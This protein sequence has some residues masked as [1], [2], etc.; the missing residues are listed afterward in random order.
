MFKPKQLIS[1]FS[2]ILLTTSTA[3]AAFTDL[4]IGQF[5]YHASKSLESQTTQNLDQKSTDL[6]NRIEALKYILKILNSQN[7]SPKLTERPRASIQQPIS[8][9]ELTPPAN[10]TNE[11]ILTEA[12]KL[13]IINDTT[14]QN[15][16]PTDPITRA[17]ALKMT[18]SLAKVNL[19]ST[20][21]SQ[22]YSDTTDKDWF[23]I[24]FRFARSHNLFDLPANRN[25]HPNQP[26]SNGELHNLIYKVKKLQSGSEFGKASFY[27]TP[28][29]IKNPTIS[30]TSPNFNY[31]L[32]ASQHDLRINSLQSYQ[33]GNNQ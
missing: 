1:I 10:P 22:A 9:P 15:F 21:S 12:I 26:L 23:T 29:E 33:I 32:T 8:N 24:Y 4:K 19:K 17:E 2:V 20:D 5:H 25:I 6:I 11:Q 30:A 18:L 27:K 13:G 31:I 3:Q 16:R 14:Y 28:R 7:P